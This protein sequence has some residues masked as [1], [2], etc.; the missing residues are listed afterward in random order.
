MQ[1]AT[2]V[3]DDNAYFIAKS[4]FFFS[5]KNFFKLCDFLKVYFYQERNNFKIYRMVKKVIIPENFYKIE[6]CCSG[7]NLCQ[8]Y[9]LFSYLKHKRHH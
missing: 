8:C 7:L 3:L 6:N 5:I 2:N 1:T 9:Q 4:H